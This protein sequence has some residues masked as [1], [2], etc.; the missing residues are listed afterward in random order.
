MTRDHSPS[1]ALDTPR[2]SAAEIRAVINDEM[3]RASGLRHVALLLG[4]LTLTGLNIALLLTEPGLP[5]AARTARAMLFALMVV[6]GSCLS[7]FSMW[8]LV[9]RGILLGVERVLATRLAATFT[10]VFA[11]GLWAVGQWGPTGRP[12]YVLM[13]AGLAM[14]AV[15][16]VLMLSARRRF[17]A[18]SRRRAALEHALGGRDRLDGGPEGGP[19]PARTPPAQ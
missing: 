11:I 2:P 17:E 14:T 9:R 5:P 1:R 8:F 10:T 12:G 4:A 18:L 16:V 6:I 3:R 13:A 19:P 7:V 15:A